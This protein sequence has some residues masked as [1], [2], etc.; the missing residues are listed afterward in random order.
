MTIE[1]HKLQTIAVIAE[2]A[3][4]YAV[5]KTSAGT[6]L[7]SLTAVP[8]LEGTST[9]TLGQAML[10]NTQAQQYI[11]QIAEDIVGI[12]SWSM[13]MTMYLASTGTA[14]DASTSSTTSPLG[15]FLKAIMGAEALSAGSTV[16]SGGGVG[17]FVATGGQGTRLT[18]GNA[19]LVNSQARKI[20]TRSTDTIT[21]AQEI[22]SVSAGTVYRS[23]TYSMVEDPDT[24]LQ[25]AVQG[26]ETHDRW[27]L[28]GGQGSFT[29]NIPIA[30]L[31]TIT[32]TLS[33]ADWLNYTG[34]ALTAASYT[35][36]SPAVVMSSEF[37]LP[38]N[39]VTARNALDVQSLSISPNI[40]Y[41]PIRTPAGVMT[42]LRMRRQRSVPA[43]TMQ[44]QTTYDA[45]T[46][47][48]GRAAR[49]DYGFAFQ[50][51][52]TAGSTVLIDIG[53]CQITDVQRSEVDPQLA[54][55]TVSLKARNDADCGTASTALERSF[56]KIYLL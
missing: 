31:P 17:G 40:N 44:F 18:A 35:A 30:G 20:K 8:F 6:S 33:G 27:I 37:T 16:A 24:S 28:M 48:T 51:G 21:Y 12:R 19:V 23:A 34:S 39:A 55:Q 50:I 47:W 22:S 1:I 56:M 36:T 7:G 41:A 11:D 5:D 52:A 4:Q 42:I 46:Y 9:L 54:G 14:A 38:T 10:P 43:A 45:Q 49:T 29:L 13:S 26:V 15:I 32:F 3:G 25:F 53:T 2:S